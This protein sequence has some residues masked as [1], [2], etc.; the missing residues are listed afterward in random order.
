MADK[1]QSWGP[2]HVPG[3]YFS[4]PAYWEKEIQD[5]IPNKNRSVKIIDCTL[6]EGEDMV[7]HVRR[8]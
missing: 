8:G 2:W 6:S 5:D 3:E 4:I 1:Q 7:G